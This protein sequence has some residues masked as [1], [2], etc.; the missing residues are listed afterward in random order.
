MAEGTV[1]QP[2]VFTS[3]FAKPGSSQP[4]ERGDWGGVI[5]LGKPL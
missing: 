2:I 1:T 4:P 3:E 5:L